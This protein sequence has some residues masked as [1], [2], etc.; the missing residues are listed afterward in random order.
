MVQLG[1]SVFLCDKKQ[2][3]TDQSRAVLLTARSM[4]IL[5]NR[6][7]AHHILKEAVILQGMQIHVEGAK[8]GFFISDLANYRIQF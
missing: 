7:I 1:H 5:E 4:E 6:G 8:V 3:P 2:G